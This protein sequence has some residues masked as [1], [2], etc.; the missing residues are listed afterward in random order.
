MRGLLGPQVVP[1]GQNLISFLRSPGLGSTSEAENGKVSKSEVRRQKGYSSS[2][3]VSSDH[4]LQALQAVADGGDDDDNVHAGGGGAAAATGEDD[5][6]HAACNMMMFR[7]NSVCFV[8]MM[9]LL[10]VIFCDG[11]CMCYL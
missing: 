9:L 11:G 4:L 3:A 1:T 5:A 2:I 6:K 10:V 7:R 8:V